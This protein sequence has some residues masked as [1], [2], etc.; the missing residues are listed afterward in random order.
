MMMA[1]SPAEGIVAEALAGLVHQFS[2]PLACFRELVQNA[3]DAGSTEIDIRFT[4]EGGRLVVDVDDYGDGMDRRIIDTKL[5]RLFSSSKDDDRTKIGRFGIGFVS[6]FALEPEVIRIDTS[7]A[8]EHWRV[9]F[10]PD[11]TFTRVA[12][13]QPVDGTKIRIYRTASEAE[14]REFA[15]RARRAIAFWCRHVPAEIRVDGRPIGEPFAAP[16][17]CSVAGDFGEARIAAGYAPDGHGV[18]GYYNRGLTLLEEPGSEFPGVILKMWSPALEHTMTRDNVLR[19][20]GHERVIGHARALVRGALRERLIE[21]LATQAP[22][23]HLPGEATE[24]LYAALARHVAADDDLPRGARKRPLVRQIDGSLIDLTTLARAGKKQTL[25]HAATRS[26]VTDLLAARGDVVIAAAG[27]SAALGLAHAAAGVKPADVNAAWCTATL[28]PAAQRPAG[29]R[30]LQA[31]LSELAG[32]SIR[33]VELGSL[34]YAG[35][36]V[37]TRV[38]IAQAEPGRLTPLQSAGALDRRPSLVLNAGHPA[39]A[40]ALTLA[41]REPELAALKLLKVFWLEGQGLSVTRAAALTSAAVE[42]R[43]RRTT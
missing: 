17:P 38:A 3:V 2:D 28:I 27:D 40:L 11:R 13:E 37:A 36:P 25:W 15:A 41:P 31:A 29:F 16:G 43:C 42:R 8:G 5:T 20:E 32:A 35:S 22:Q 21:V 14:A 18:V 23:L 33:G 4:H 7:R 1:E 39:V 34:E 9:I 26:P 10:R 30:E 24:H 19:D 6:V 12:R